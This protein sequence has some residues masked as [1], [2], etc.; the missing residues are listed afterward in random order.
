MLAFYHDLEPVAKK[1]K[2]F[3]RSHYAADTTAEH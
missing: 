3:R 1:I 2:D